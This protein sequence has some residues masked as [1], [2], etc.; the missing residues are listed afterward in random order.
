MGKKQRF[1]SKIAACLLIMIMVVLAVNSSLLSASAANRTYG[2][3][4][5]DT[6]R[7]HQDGAPQPADSFGRHTGSIYNLYYDTGN[8][9]K[10][11][12]YGNYGYE[13]VLRVGGTWA[14]VGN[15]EDG[16]K[17]ACAPDL[18]INGVW[19]EAA[20]SEI[21]NGEHSDSFALVTFKLH[22]ITGETK[23]AD[24]ATMADLDIGGD[25]N[26]P[27][28]PLRINGQTNG[29]KATNQYMIGI[30]ESDKIQLYYHFNSNNLIKRNVT[31]M[32][33]GAWT[34]RF[35]CMWN[36]NPYLKVN[37]DT[38]HSG[39]TGDPSAVDTGFA[40]SWQGIEIAPYGTEEITFTLDVIKAQAEYTVKY[41]GNGATSGYTADQKCKYNE[42]F[43]ISANGYSKTGYTFTGWNTEK[44][45]TADNPG[46]SYNPGDTVSDLIPNNG[47]TVTLYAQWTPNTYYVLYDNN[48]GNAADWGDGNG[49][50]NVHRQTCTYDNSYSVLANRY[51]KDGY[52][53]LGW[54][55][56]R[57]GNGEWYYVDDTF[58]NL[59]SENN[60]TKTLYA[61]WGEA[62]SFVEYFGNGST[63]GSNYI[64]GY[65]AVNSDTY[66]NGSAFNKKGYEF[67]YWS[68][69]SQSGI[70]LGGKTGSDF[71]ENVTGTTVIKPK[72][73]MG[74]CIDIVGADYSDYA[75]AGIYPCTSGDNQI[76]AFQWAGKDD[77]GDYY[78]IRSNASGKVLDVD[79]GVMDGDDNK[80]NVRLNKHVGDS[81]FQ[82]WYVEINDDYVKIRSRWSGGYLDNCGNSLYIYAGNNN[83]SQRWT[84]ERIKFNAYAQWKADDYIIKFDANG[85]TLPGTGNLNNPDSWEHGN[86]TG[87]D[88]VK[89]T[90]GETFFYDMSSDIPTKAY[91]EFTGW[92]DSETGDK[93]YDK[94]GLCV[95]GTGYWEDNKWCYGKDIEVYAGYK[96]TVEGVAALR[97][98][99]NGGTLTGDWSAVNN[100]WTVQGLQLEF[101]ESINS[102]K[103]VG[104]VSVLK[105]NVYYNVMDRLPVQ[106]G[107][108]FLGWFDKYGEQVYFPDGKCKGGTYWDKDYNDSE[109]FSDRA[110]WKSDDEEVVLYAH[111]EKEEYTV[112]LD[113]NKPG[114]ALNDVEYDESYGLSFEVW[115]KHNTNKNIS[116]Y[117]PL[118]EGY[119]FLG[120][121]TSRSGGKQVYDS[122][123]EMLS[124]TGY[125]DENGNWIYEGDVT[126]FAHWTDNRP[127][128]DL[129]VNNPDSIGTSKA[130][131]LTLTDT[132][133]GVKG[134]YWG[135]NNNYTSNTYISVSNDGYKDT[136]TSTCT[137]AL[138]GIY[139]LT[140]IDRSG[141]AS[142]TVQVTFNKTTFDANG[143][144]VSPSYSINPYRAVLDVTGVAAERDGYYGGDYDN[145][146]GKSNDWRTSTVS[147]S[148]VVSYTVTKNSALYAVWNTGKYDL[149][150]NHFVMDT[151]GNYPESP[152]KTEKLIKAAG[153]EIIL[154]NLKSTSLE[155]ENIIAYA[156]GMFNDEA[157]EKAVLTSDSIINLYY[158]RKS[159]TVSLQGDSGIDTEKLTGAGVYYAG[160]EVTVSAEVLE[161]H[162]W[163]CW[164]GDFESNEMEF[165]FVMPSKNVWFY[166]STDKRYYTLKYDGNK[167]I[168]VVNVPNTITA[169]YGKI[170]QLSN[171]VPE[172]TGY[173]FKEWNT[174]ADGSGISYKPGESVSDITT[175][176]QYTITLYGQWKKKGINLIKAASDRYYDSFVKCTENDNEWYEEVGKYSVY[177]VIMLADA[178]SR[179]IWNINKDGVITREK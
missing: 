118:L 128:A 174:E 133:S 131:S 177:Q 75:Q 150:I 86:K 143:G 147:T 3:N 107:C 19:C 93:V 36:N 161:G 47:S 21:P 121:F 85:G 40:V 83:D 175:G 142:Q 59:I 115:Y 125:W 29:F 16:Q 37:N 102:T 108:K 111:W 167:G 156:Y 12:T 42:A 13:T 87:N 112:T 55:T 76:F 94:N 165:I 106:D 48:W 90:T 44:N 22:N 178:K 78:V 126:L 15:N 130:V 141:N 153:E 127:E 77:K 57:D 14:F 151:D 136:C 24:L 34:D 138:S 56:E 98:N 149:Q 80:H 38:P 99:A 124:G 176:V 4:N 139:Y 116:H 169:E 43:T 110:K 157:V 171:L 145:N 179:Q 17:A 148:R 113:F 35:D 135:T 2:N 109:E 74:S 97:F 11:T 92:Y 84:L 30:D 1:L 117:D 58:I 79:S 9:Q 46:Y 120:W 53:F 52:V 82:Q 154:H 54:N 105:D 72:N 25:D 18:T 134:Y 144:T 89:V 51:T 8:G 61:Q 67:D 146:S 23:T 33:V 81:V 88:W 45:P 163:Q 155:T 41:D 28:T 162:I 173:C 160:A 50:V 49:S 64:K 159:Y 62:R 32:W 26:A 91:N 172:R 65:R 170:I 5:W 137:V 63:E 73:N 7:N 100:W 69:F 27:I 152:Q 71:I 101:K 123:G 166:A 6:T 60:G 39:S 158:E 31:T 96:S 10:A 114:Y 168:A 20:V 122:K 103:T 104:T 129:H 95:N 164:N 66:D 68:V 140:A 119:E 70:G 132:G